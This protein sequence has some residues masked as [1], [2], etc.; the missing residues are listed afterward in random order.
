[1]SAPSLDPA[2]ERIGRPGIV[3][4]GLAA[5]ALAYWLSVVQPAREEIAALRARL[6]GTAPVRVLR[7]AGK[8]RDA[9]GITE[10]LEVLPAAA[11]LPDHVARLNALASAQTVLLDKADGKMGR[12]E[13]RLLRYELALPIRGDYAGIR[14]FLAGVLNSMPFVAL[15]ALA[16]TRRDPSSDVVE[17]QLTLTFF[18]NGS[19]D[20]ASGTGGEPSGSRS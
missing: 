11:T 16:V 7:D 15:D 18:L 17:A 14:R 6:V 20:T 1:V 12:A 8:D 19:P 4:L 3:G 5:F 13:G 9:S 10:F 2:L